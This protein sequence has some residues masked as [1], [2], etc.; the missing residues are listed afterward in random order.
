LTIPVHRR[1]APPGGVTSIRA[2]LPPSDVIEVRGVRV[3]SPARTAF[4]LARDTGP[5]ER[6]VAGVDAM[7]HVHLLTASLLRAYLSNHAGWKRVPQVRAV[8]A[9]A[10][11]GAENPMETMLR[12]FWQSVT[13]RRLLAN[14]YIFDRAGEFVGRADILD[15]DIATVGQFDGDVHSSRRARTMDARRRR[16]YE[17]AGLAVVQAT[18]IDLLGDRGPLEAEIRRTERARLGRDRTGDL[19]TLK[20]PDRRP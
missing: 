5:Y 1:L 18:S 12:L 13:G 7:L 6:A 20:R 9:D 3:T 19:W 14:R 8:L 17:H 2:P 15:E 4:E 11:A 10:D 16:A